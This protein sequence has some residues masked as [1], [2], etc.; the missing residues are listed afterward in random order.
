[1]VQ[2]LIA[3]RANRSAQST[4]LILRTLILSALCRYSKPEC[5]LCASYLSIQQSAVHWLRWSR[6]QNAAW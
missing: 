1:M 5:A 4:H 6:S 3:N 2:L